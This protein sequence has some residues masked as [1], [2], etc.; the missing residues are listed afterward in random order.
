MHV[1]YIGLG[2][3]LD[4]PEQ[5]IEQALTAL[6][7]IPLTR[8]VTVSPRYASSPIGPQDQP[9]FINA[10]AC[11]STRLSPLALLDQLQALEQ[12]HRR[13]RLRHWGPRTLDLDV[14]TFDDQSLDLP[15]LKVPHPAC[16]NALSCWSPWRI[17][18]PT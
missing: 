1:A 3:N 16:M 8:L 15:R 2:S 5:R 14:L 4:G 10:V 12:A 7:R 6:N 13:R 11:V 17:S 18:L 9:D